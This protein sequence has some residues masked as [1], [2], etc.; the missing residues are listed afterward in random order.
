MPRLDRI[1]KQ[2]GKSIYWFLWVIF[3]LVILLGLLIIGSFIGL[4]IYY[5]YN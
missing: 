2:F 4:S 5:N 3:G 1:Q